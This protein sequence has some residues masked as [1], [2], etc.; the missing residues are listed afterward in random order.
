M[1][2]STNVNKPDRIH[3][4][5]EGLGSTEGV[6][7]CSGRGVHD[8]DEGVQISTQRVEVPAGVHELPQGSGPLL[9]HA[10]FFEVVQKAD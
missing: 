6:E 10:I 2:A 7:T 4:D 5:V 9:V 3:V 8:K 1:L